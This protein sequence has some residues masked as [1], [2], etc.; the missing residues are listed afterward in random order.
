MSDP[1]A[2]PRPVKASLLDDSNVT[3]RRR[4]TIE[5]ELEN[6]A[7]KKSRIAS[8]WAVILSVNRGRAVDKSGHRRRM[9]QHDTRIDDSR[10]GSTPAGLRSG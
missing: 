2:I 4:G 3:S 6:G 9:I 7:C 8:K 5:R 10:D 1:P